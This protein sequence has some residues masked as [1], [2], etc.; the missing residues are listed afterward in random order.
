LLGSCRVELKN[1]DR[2]LLGGAIEQEAAQLAPQGWKLHHA[3]QPRITSIKSGDRIPGT[4]AALVGN[5]APNFQLDLLDG[6]T[7]HL[8]D[9]AGQIVVLDFWASW[10]GPCIQTMPQIDQLIRELPEDRVRLVAVN[11]QESPKQISAVLERLELETVVALDVDGVVAEK[12]TATAIPQTV[13]IDR[14][15]NI[16][17]LFIGGGPQ[18]LEHLREALEGLLGDTRFSTPVE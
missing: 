14:E 7:F 17:R 5:Q 11:L 12:Y 10:C 16:A 8:Q 18:V 1:I 4:A 2:L 13:V 9:C 3:Q 15:G 6:E